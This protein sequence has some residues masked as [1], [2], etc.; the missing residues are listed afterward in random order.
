MNQAN[1]E[2]Q[3]KVKYEFV[4]ESERMAEV[5]DLFLEYVRSLEVDLEVDLDFQDYEAELEQLPGEYA[6]P[7]G[8]LL[9]AR[10]PEEAVGCVALRRISADT[11]ELK[12]LY[13]RPAYRGRG[14]GRKLVSLL[15]K[16]AEELGYRY[17]RL[18]TLADLE[19]A[20]KL[21]RSFGF[22][23]I[24]PYRYNPLVG[25]IYLELDL[26]QGGER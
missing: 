9:L 24:K 2:P 4:S 3:E 8:A 11:C 26:R 7:E 19:K 15:L 17:V 18:D 22:E 1:A 13:V 21:Y 5:K 20:L 12:R 6:P 23:E 25:A 16:K 10:S 14:I